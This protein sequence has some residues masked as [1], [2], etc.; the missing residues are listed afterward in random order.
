VKAAALALALQT[1]FALKDGRRIE[2][3]RVPDAAER[4]LTADGVHDSSRVPR[5]RLKI[6]DTRELELS[7]EELESPQ[8]ELSRAG[9]VFLLEVDPLCDAGRLCG[10]C[11]YVLGA[12]G[13][14]IF[15]IDE[16]S[17]RVPVRMFRSPSALWRIDPSG[18]EILAVE[19][20]IG[21]ADGDEVPSFTV[22]R[23]FWLDVTGRWHVRSREEPGG[24]E[25][26]N[27]TELPPRYRFP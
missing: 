5:A 21:L 3:W 12:H 7:V 10:P 4:T 18:R 2:L 13:Q 9:S 22:L 6:L 1:A 15:A 8:A 11:T 14:R 17:E 19:T 20:R 24:F 26:H 23:R 16:R 25:V 27:R